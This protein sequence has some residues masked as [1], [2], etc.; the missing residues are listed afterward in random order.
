MVAALAWRT[1]VEEAQA[2]LNLDLADESRSLP[3]HS[4]GMTEQSPVQV[5]RAG[6]PIAAAPYSGTSSAHLTLSTHPQLVD[7]TK[8]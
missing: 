1:N 4:C 8:R 5:F 3:K 6:S 7:R 2:V